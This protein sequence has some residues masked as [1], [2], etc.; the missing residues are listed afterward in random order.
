MIIFG[1]ITD[2]SKSEYRSA[3]ALGFFDGVH[4]GHK[5]VIN[6]CREN[7]EKLKCTVLT[8]R[9]SPSR[10][11]N[12]FVPLLS[13]NDDK[14]GLIEKCGADALIYADFEKIKN[15]EA[16]DFINDV[17]IKKLH[18]EKI[19]CGF[20]YRFGKDGK[21]DTELLRK[22][23]EE[24]GIQVQIC[25]P[26]YCN[27]EMISSTAVREH[28]QNGEIET[29]NRMLGYSFSISGKIQEGLHNGKDLSFPTINIPLKEEI[30]KP[31]FG[32]YRSEVTIKHRTYAGATNIGMHPTM[33]SVAPLCE[34][35]LIEYEGESLYNEFASVRLLEFIR[36][37]RKFSSREELIHQIEKD[38]NQIINSIKY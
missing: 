7:C 30:V 38:K 15:I 17:L 26:V 24:K 5:K 34:T 19:F 14:A 22:I 21:G 13:D 28:I 10:S 2:Y 1:S 29:A 27:G 33:G 18:T 35:N 20:N 32:V 25:E 36:E 16:E 6:T 4:L 9:N 23:C 31:K 3:V 37:E 12:R 8:F 11:F